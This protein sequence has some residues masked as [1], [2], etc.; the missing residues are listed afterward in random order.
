MKKLFT[1]L[2]LLAATALSVVAETD[3]WNALWCEDNTTLYFVA[4][5]N[6]YA[7]GDSFTPADGSAAVTLTNVWGKTTNGGISNRSWNSTVRSK[8]TRVVFEPSF[9]NF[10]P[11]YAHY[12]FNSCSLLKTVEGLENLNTERLN[13]MDEMFSGC[14][15]LENFTMTGKNTDN[16]QT[17]QSMFSGCKALKSLNLSG[18]TNPALRAAGYL[19]YNCEALESVNLSGFGTPEVTSFSQM[20]YG[21]KALKTIDL[22]SFD[23]G[24]VTSVSSMFANCAALESVN[25]AGWNTASLTNMSSMFNGCAALTRADLSSWKNS[26]LTDMNSAFVNCAAL[27]SVDLSGFYTVKLNNTTNLFNGCSA[28]ESVSV[29][30]AWTLGAVTGSSGMFRG[31]TSIVGQDGTTYDAAYTD[32]ARAH[33][34]PGGYLRHNAAGDISID[35]SPAAIWC[36]DNATLYFTRVDALLPA[37]SSFV[38]EGGAAVTV[39]DAWIGDAVLARPNNINSQVWIATVRDAME[40]IVIESKF[41]EFHP[42]MVQGWMQNCVKLTDVTGMANLKLD[43]VNSMSSMFSG[44]SAL[45]SLSLAGVDVSNV[46]NYY[47]MFYNCKALRSVDLSG[48]DFAAAVDFGAMFAG[49]AALESVDFG[50]MSNSVAESFN[51]MFNGCTSL[52]SV[53]LSGFRTVKLRDTASMFNGCSALESAS[54]SNGWSLTSVTSSGNMFRG[55]TSIVGQDGTTYDASSIDKTRAHYGPGGYLRHNAAGDITIDPQPAVVWCA[56]NAT[57]YFTW[58]DRLLPA[59][60]PFVTEGGAT[61]SVTTAWLGGDVLARPNTTHPYHIWRSTVMGA[62]QHAVIESKFAQAHP[63]EVVM[64][65]YGCSKLEDVTGMANLKLDQAGNL[66]NMFYGC[67]SLKSVDLDKLDASTVKY[68]NCMFQG[69]KSLESIDLSSLANAPLT[70]QAIYDMFNGCSSLKTIDVSMLNTASTTA[71]FRMFKD[72]AALESITFGDFNTENQTNMQELFSG[73]ASLT[74]LELS[75]FDTRKVRD[76]SRMFNG[77]A[78]LKSIYVGSYWMTG[79][80]SSTDMFKGCEAIEG[81]DGTGYD[82]TSVDRTRAHYNAGGYLRKGRMT[83]LA[84]AVPAV[85]W[86]ADNKTLYFTYTTTPVFEG[87]NFMPEGTDETH[88]ISSMWSDDEVVNTPTTYAPGWTGVRSAV[89]R[90]VVEPSF[91][92]VKPVSLYRWFYSFSK[93]EQIVGLN[94]LNTS[95]ATSTAWMFGNCLLTNLDLSSFD[96]RK[97]EDMSAM[98]GYMS[99]IT[100]LDLSSFLPFGVSYMTQMFVN[101]SA[102]KTIKVNSLWNIGSNASTSNM[103]AGCTSIV[104]QDGTTYNASSTDGTRAHYGAGGYL[105]HGTDPELTEP[106]PMVLITTDGTAY[107]ITSLEAYHAGDRYTPAA[108]GGA[109]TVSIA[110]IGGDA[111]NYN[112][113]K[114]IDNWQNDGLDIIKAVVIEPSFATLRLTTIESYFSE[115]AAATSITGLEYLNTAEVTNMNWLFEG[116]SSLT[117]LDLSSFETSKLEST[118]QMFSGCRKLKSIYVSST[119]TMANIDDDAYM[120]DDCVSLV[121]EDGTGYNEEDINGYRA[122]YCAGGYLRHGTDRVIDPTPAA[123]ACFDTKALYFF[124][125]TTPIVH[126]GAFTLPGSG[127]YRKATRAAMGDRVTAGEKGIIPDWLLDDNHLI[128][129]IA[130]N[131]TSAVIDPSFAA[132]KPTSVAA[133]FYNCTG[134]RLVDGLQY[135]DTSEATDMLAMFFKCSNLRSLDLSNFDTHKVTDMNGMFAD[136]TTLESIYVGEQWNTDAVTS[137]DVMFR[138]CYSLVGEDGTRF[139]LT[140]TDKSRAHYGEGGYLR[141]H[142]SEYV[143]TLPAAGYT[144]FSAAEALILPDGLDAYIVTDGDPEAAVATATLVEGRIV[145]ANLGVLLRGTAGATYTLT[146]T[147]DAE[148]DGV[149][150]DENLLRA[151][152]VPTVVQAG[153]FDTEDGNTTIMRLCNLVLQ[154]ER[155][156]P[157]LLHMT[158][159]VEGVNMPA[160]TAYLALEN[161]TVTV[162]SPL[163]LRIVWTEGNPYD[164]NGDGSVNVGDVNTVLNLILAEA[165]DAKCDVNRDGM[166]NV[167]DVNVILADILSNQ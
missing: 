85:I 2:L 114:H 55:C 80:A 125:T 58:T 152:T 166:V 44:C 69:C 46:T 106:V 3:K 61:V 23:T 57:M 86:C 134:L 111:R 40:H 13:R 123:A 24:K 155:F 116:C 163:R 139:K 159:E 154:G 77:C 1:L 129:G 84:E 39:S 31:C 124:V 122:H 6:S 76:M 151:V 9:K 25:L 22:S 167:G 26:V 41:A 67:E 130:K 78:K 119:W 149:R 164:V 60:S 120:F 101:C 8:V 64:W 35:P 105:T 4:T 73:C 113:W 148:A 153:L 110:I 56:D 135:L 48:V 142:H 131:V 128:E 63:T 158:P 150:L 68:V 71:M 94:N 16:L 108:G 12:W 45:Q 83:V 90:V 87:G 118:Y 162:S 28:L 107:F 74:T 50:G 161:V 165:Y 95:E 43:K 10:Y 42:T 132:V 88:I 109:K 38:T 133:W 138:G 92:A 62:V 93:L 98:F 143:V 47:Q 115:L 59:G 20:F 104:G 30:N 70:G 49:C 99:Q 147:D 141:R 103:F 7:A 157:V 112:W 32:K 75:G 91:A 54:V 18:W 81:E 89:T 17:V 72:C 126:G 121:G 156:E 36:A 137:S 27:K 21:C 127:T 66:G 33:Y 11:D 29:S 146:A 82:A 145:P 96:T 136:C 37:G 15:S 52:Q 144:T 53:D 102:L 97:V 34:G 51:S 140:D 100:E 79:Y 117:E 14:T 5:G 65:F 160:N 19:C